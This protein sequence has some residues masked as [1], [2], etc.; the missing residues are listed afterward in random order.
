L[1][2]FPQGICSFLL[3][4]REANSLDRFDAERCKA[5]AETCTYYNG[6]IHA[7]AFLLPQSLKK[8]IQE[9]KP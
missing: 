2:S 9:I 7:G 8:K 6:D 5:I 1:S 4:G 3:C